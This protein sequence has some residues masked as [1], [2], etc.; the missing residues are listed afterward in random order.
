[1]GLTLLGATE[2][3][4]VISGIAVTVLLRLMAVRHDW[5]LPG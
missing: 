2:L 4:A 5:K 1:L 3:F